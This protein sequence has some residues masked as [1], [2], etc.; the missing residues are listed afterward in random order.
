MITLGL[1][2]GCANHSG[3]V[4][5][6][7]MSL[8]TSGEATNRDLGGQIGK[9]VGDNMRLEIKSDGTFVATMFGAPVNG[10]WTQ[11]GDVI[12]FVPDVAGKAQPAMV[13]I[14]LRLANNGQH[15]EPVDRNPTQLTQQIFVRDGS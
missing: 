3:P 8:G 13:N 6:W 9:A 1:L 11:E 5:K 2:V 4:G 7:K 10:K 12:S 15:L 14:R